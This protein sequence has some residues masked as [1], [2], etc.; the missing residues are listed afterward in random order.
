MLANRHPAYV[1]YDTASAKYSLNDEQAL[2]LAD[3]NSPVDLPGAYSIVQ[4]CT[5]QRAGREN[6]RQRQGHGMGEHHPCLFHGTERFFRAGYTPTC[7][8]LVPPWRC[9]AKTDRARGLRT[10]AAVT[11]R[12]RS[13][14]KGIPRFAVR[15][16]YYHDASIETAR[17]RARGRGEQC[18]IRDGRRNVLRERELTSSPSSTACMTWRSCR[19]RPSRPPALSGWELHD[20]R[21]IAGDR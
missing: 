4:D 17:R 19:R 1:E 10:S 12:A 2:C 13:S 18:Q 7:C 6:F 11:V 16:H 20:C 8:L 3:P 21:A 15:R 5:H 9:G 14:W